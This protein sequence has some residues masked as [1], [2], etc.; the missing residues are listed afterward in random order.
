MHAIGIKTIRHDLASG[1][2]MILHTNDW[3][4]QRIRCEEAFEPAVRREFE[5]VASRKVNVIDIGANIGYY[6]IIAAGLIGPEKRVFAV[7]PQTAVAAKLRRN[8]EMNRLSNVQIEQIALSDTRGHVAFHVPTDGAEAHGS[9]RMNGTFE[10]MET[11]EVE[12]QRLDDMMARLG[13]P[14]IGLIKLDAEGAELLI[15]HGATGLLSSPH[16]P[17]LIFEACEKN[18]QP[19]GH[20]VFDVLRYVHSFGYQVRQLDDSDWIAEA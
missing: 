10:V 20:C 5:R 1:A 11:I 17:V 2:R 8:L 16:K 15:L 7:E 9:M 4:A 14:E 18:C 19:F 13:N 6:S 12:T 3:V